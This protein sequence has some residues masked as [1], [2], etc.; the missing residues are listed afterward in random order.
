[1]C[2]LLV[3]G[4]L[5][6]ITQQI[7]SLRASGVMSSH[8]ASAAGSE[9]RTLRRSVGTLCTAPGEMAF[10]VI[11]F[12]FYRPSDRISLG[13]PGV[14]LFRPDPRASEAAT[15]R[16]RRKVGHS[17]W[18]GA[19][20]AAA[21]RR[22]SRIS[23]SSRTVLSS[24]SAFAASILRSMRGRPSGANITAISSSEKPAGTP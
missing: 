3:S 15:R 14:L 11:D 2:C 24:S 5:T 1:M 21:C 12:I 13:S 18:L 4:F 8:F 20:Q 19:R 10:L 16:M 9:M 23:L 17:M 22:P 7:H 6:E